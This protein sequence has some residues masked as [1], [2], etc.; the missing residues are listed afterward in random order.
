VLTAAGADALESISGMA[1]FNGVNVRIE[2]VRAGG[3]KPPVK[4]TVPA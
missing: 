2:R 4:E 1:H 3:T